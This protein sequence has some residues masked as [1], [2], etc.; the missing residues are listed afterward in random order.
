MDPFSAVLSGI[1]CLVL[2]LWVVAGN[3][4]ALALVFVR[5]EECLGKQAGEQEDGDDDLKHGLLRSSVW[6]E[7][8]Q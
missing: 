7:G 1:S 4:L 8:G 5:Y 6:P 3:M 2:I